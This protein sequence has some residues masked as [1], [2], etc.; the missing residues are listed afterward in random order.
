[1]TPRLDRLRASLEEPLLLT[2]PVNVRYLVGFKSSNAALLVGDER[3]TLFTDFRYVTAAREVEGVDFVETKRDLI[4]DLASRLS[5]RVGFESSYLSYAAYERLRAGG[6]E[7]VPRPGAVESLRA[8]KDDEELGAIRR[9]CAITDRVYERL[10]KETFV[11]RTELDI[12]WTLEQLFHDEGSSAAFESVVASGPNAAKPHGRATD[13]EIGRGETVVIDAGCIVDGY[14]SDYTRTF[15]T[16]PLPEELRDAYGV[17]L[18]AQAAALDAIR[19]GVSG[20]DADRAARDVVD[21]TPF[22]GRFGHGL[23]HGT[24][25]EIHEA[26]RMSQESKDVLAP[27]NVVTVEPG[28]YL[29][30]HG[31][32]RIEDDVVVTDGGIDNLTN[33]R[34]GL[35]E[36]G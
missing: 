33:L 25:L 6:L 2:N 28:I 8:V 19:S 13:R 9:A 4:G 5:G 22:A 15:A 1:M 35:I 36:V 3:V 26:P 18:D 12:A 10:A 31:G 24:G 11:G 23:G 17:C 21:A 32:I 7:L 16:G 30:G 27:G 20:I 34:K 14:V 29:E